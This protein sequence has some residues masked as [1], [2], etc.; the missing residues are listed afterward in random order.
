MPMSTGH[1]LI[2]QYVFS[3]YVP[4]YIYLNSFLIVSYTVQY[5]FIYRISYLLNVILV[6][7]IYIYIRMHIIHET[8][9]ENVPK[10]LKMLYTDMS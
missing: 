1:L 9:S 6:W 10:E 8:D 5:G 4:Y 2:L 7:H 3:I